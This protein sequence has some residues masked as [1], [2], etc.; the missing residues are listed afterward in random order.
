MCSPFN[1]CHRLFY[2]TLRRGTEGS[3]NSNRTAIDL[4]SKEHFVLAWEQSSSAGKGEGKR[5][6]KRLS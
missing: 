2:N 3:F 1:K 5:S 6:Q 4:S